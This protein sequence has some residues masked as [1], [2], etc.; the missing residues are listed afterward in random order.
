MSD[1]NESVMQGDSEAEVQDEGRNETKEGSAGA[2]D[3]KKN[4]VS[5]PTPAPTSTRAEGNPVAGL[6]IPA[7]GAAEAEVPGVVPDR[8]DV[9][10]PTPAGTASTLQS[11]F[12]EKPTTPE[13]EKF[14][15]ASPRATGD[16]C[17]SRDGDS[18][19]ESTAGSG[20]VSAIGF[21]HGWVAS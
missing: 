4:F 18:S 3:A 17:A 20:G 19:A 15:T 11:F 16:G 9:A 8:T 7:G 10:D 6:A 5:D 13:I 12:V 1:D 21:G 2:K 14:A